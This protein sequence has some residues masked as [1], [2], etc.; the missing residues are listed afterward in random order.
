MTVSSSATKPS[1]GEGRDGIE[2]TKL[3]GPNLRNVLMPP[4][5]RISD[6]TLCYGAGL[7]VRR[8]ERGQV[9]KVSAV[10]DFDLYGGVK[11]MDGRWE[12][13]MGINYVYYKKPV[14]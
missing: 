6:M 7:P 11:G 4:E 9:W 5:K 3:V 2:T 12:K 13:V 8:I 10:Y 14:L 1:S